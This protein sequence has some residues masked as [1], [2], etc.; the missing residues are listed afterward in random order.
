MVMTPRV[1]KAALTGHVTCSVGWLGAVTAFLALA[2]AGLLG[3]DAA[4]VRGAYLSLDLLIWY[5]IVPLSVAASA[6]GLVQS[7]G[8]TWGLIRHHWVLIKVVLTIPATLVLFIHTRPVGAVAR[9]AFDPTFPSDDLFK[10]RVQLVVAAAAAVLVLLV[11][12]GLAVYKPRGLS[13][14]GRRRL[15]SEGP[16]RSALVDGA[17]AD[18][19][20]PT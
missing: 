1:R 2:L 4:R 19:E 13:R 16:Q 3:S 7:L 14:Y 10:A 18:G 17:R 5:V 11:V 6:T 9:A 8:T 15:G 12:T 20:R